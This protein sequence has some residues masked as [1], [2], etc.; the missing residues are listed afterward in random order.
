MFS[1]EQYSSERQAGTRI[2]SQVGG[3]HCGPPCTMD[4]LIHPLH[5]MFFLFFFLITQL[6]EASFALTENYIVF[7]EQ[8]LKIELRKYL[9]LVLI[10]KPFS[11]MFSWNPKENVSLRLEFH[12]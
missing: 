1:V 7:M 10:G 11:E 2:L 8:P 4:S 9:S 6:N 12:S 5:F 3:T